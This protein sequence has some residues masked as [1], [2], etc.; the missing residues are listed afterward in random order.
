MGRSGACE[1]YREAAILDPGHFRALKLLG[2]ALFGLGEYPAAEE[3]LRH[4]LYLS[5]EYAF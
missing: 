3:A 2:S 4:S 1:H 5:A